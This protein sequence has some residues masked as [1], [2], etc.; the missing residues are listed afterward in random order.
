MKALCLLELGRLELVDAPKPEPGPGELLIKTGAAAICTSDL[1]DIRENVFGAQLPIIMGHEGAGEVAAVGSAAEGF[2]VGDPVAAHPV[3]PCGRCVNCR[4]NAAHLCLDMRHFGLN[5]PG[6]F[7]EY[8][9]V[10][11]D[12]AR[13]TSADVAMPVAA[14]FEPVCVCLQALAQTKTN[15]DSSLLIVGDGPFGV[16]MARLARRM[17]VQNVV[18]AGH[19]DRRL[20][21]AAAAGTRC[22]NTATCS[23]PGATLLAATDGNGY[24]A[25]I[26]TIGSAR[27]AQNALDLLRAKGRLVLFA[28]SKEP[29]AF[30]AFRI[31]TQELEIV[32]ACNDEDRLDDAVNLLGDRELDLA[33]VVTHTFSVEEYGKAFDLAEHGHST[34]LKIALTFQP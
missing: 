13:K 10:R 11:A 3:H 32:G 6:T 9:M 29:I 25:V 8:F 16:I 20:A 2:C 26:V 31:H 17:G 1:Q 14:L 24:D 15:K 4:H 18:V 19:H 34:A 7:A 23:S 21:T 33:S 28:A 12:R 5:M 30:D 27:A 22:V